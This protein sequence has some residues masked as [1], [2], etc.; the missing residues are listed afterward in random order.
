M[1]N[2]IA[3]QFSKANIHRRLFQSPTPTEVRVGRYRLLERVG[4]GAMG[5]VFAA[6][7]ELLQRTVALKILHDRFCG[8]R[9]TQEALALA[10][11]SHPNTITVHDIG[12]E[13]GQTFISM[14]F[15]EGQSLRHWRHDQPRSWPE[16]LEK[17]LD[18]GRGLAAAHEQG[19]V[20]RDFKPENVLIDK[21]GRVQVADFGLAIRVHSA[22]PN[23]LTK[24]AAKARIDALLT[25]D[26]WAGTPAY[27]SPE[28]FDGRA[29]H[30]SD[31]FAFAVCVFEALFEKRPYSGTTADEIRRQAA[32]GPIQSVAKTDVPPRI[33]RA[34]RRALHPIPHE[35]YPT[36]HD[37]MADLKAP[38]SN[39]PRAMT[40]AV[41]S[42]TVGLGLL[43]ITL[44]NSSTSIEPAGQKP[45]VTAPNAT[46]D[47]QRSSLAVLPFIDMS[48]ESPK[49]QYDDAL[50]RELT[51][52]LSSFS[53]LRVAAEQSSLYFKERPQP[54]RQIG[55]AL[56]VR[57]LLDGSVK[58][59]ETHIQIK[60]ELFD[61]ETGSHPWART[62]SQPLQNAANIH[63]EIARAVAQHLQVRDVSETVERFD[64]Y[65]ARDPKAHEAFRLGK[66]A[67]R[68][69]SAQGV[70]KAIVLLKQ[71]VALDETYV[72]ALS[73]L[74]YAHLMEAYHVSGIELEATNA[75]EPLL[76]RALTL[77]PD[78]AEAHVAAGLMHHLRREYVTADEH[79][80]R[81]IDIN[82][83]LMRAHNI[84]GLNFLHQSRL[85]DASASYLQAQT[86]NPMS[87]SITYNFAALL[88]LMGRYDEGMRLLDR[89]HQLDP[90][91]KITAAKIFF[92][93]KFGRLVDAIKLAHDASAQ[94]QDDLSV[95]DVKANA[96][97][98]LGFWKEA[99]QAFRY[100]RQKA[101]GRTPSIGYEL[102]WAWMTLEPSTFRRFIDE[103]INSTQSRPEWQRRLL[104]RYMASAQL[105]DGESDA[106]LESILKAW[107]GDTSQG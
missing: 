35:R 12:V 28:Q 60:A 34:L 57:Y 90:E 14:A 26:S 29:D 36:L 27:M 4:S 54:L 62:F 105:R 6:H 9:F 93:S 51:Q 22:A 65:R 102:A 86:L 11:V 101:P 17:W 69:R 74:A 15:V 63:V 43:S 70:Q 94:Q 85:K 61:V 81:A 67:L 30:R 97:T 52:R 103:R 2:T 45:T 92:S 104:L 96:L 25:T 31:Q 16:I 44:Q 82:P 19:L 18:A 88:M 48:L 91:R 21:N 78:F 55:Q 95:I 77:A 7:D 23:L 53:K 80:A 49:A 46:T 10:K 38:P 99:D 33:L 41:L 79:L 73:S 106:A 3:V 58:K 1:T 32:E 68:T 107:T 71:A 20:H 56:G 24:Y 5:V 83:N 64:L 66:S 39:V 72:P 50:T 13:G 76:D 8:P 100:L 47:T 59:K 42:L 84:R 37:L 75:A 98:M 40:Y 89:T 87:S